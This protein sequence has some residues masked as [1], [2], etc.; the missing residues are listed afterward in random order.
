MQNQ[1]THTPHKDHAMMTTQSISRAAAGIRYLTSRRWIILSAGL[2]LLSLSAAF[3]FGLR[4]VS[5]ATLNVPGTYPTIQAAVNAAA[6]G[7]T[8]IVAAGTYTETVTIPAAK[9]GLI[10]RGA[11]AGVD[12]RNPRGA[13]SI[14]NG[15]GGGFNVQASNVVIDGFTVRDTSGGL[16][17]GIVV[18]GSVSGVKILNNI[19]RDN[20]IGLYLNGTN[21]EARQNYFLNNTLA[22]PAGGNAIYSDGGTNG[23]IVDKNRFEGHDSSAMVFA[24]P[25]GCPAPFINQNLT[26]TNN[27]IL[28]QAGI[29]LFDTDTAT[30]QGNT[31]QDTTTSGVYLGGNDKNIT[32]NFNNFS[33]APAT[34][35]HNG[36]TIDNA[37]GIYCGNGPGLNITN[38]NFENLDCAIVLYD[39]ALVDGTTVEAHNNRIVG[40]E[41]VGIHTDATN[42]TVDAGQNWWGCNDVPSVNGTGG[43]TCHCNGVGPAG[44]QSPDPIP[45]DIS[46]AGPVINQNNVLQLTLHATPDTLTPGGM[47]VVQIRIEGLN[48]PNNVPVLLLN[49]TGSSVG[50]SITP[51]IPA[52]SLSLTGGA[53]ALAKFTAG[54]PGTAEI[55]VGVDCQDPPVTFLINVPDINVGPGD[56]P[57]SDSEISDQKAGSMLVYNYYTSS[58]ANPAQENARINIT[59]T[60]PSRSVNVHLF[61]IDGATCS[62]A[63]SFACLTPNQTMTF[64]AADIDP[65][66]SGY[67]VALAID[68]SGCPI[69]FNYLIGD[70]YVKQA[71]GHAANLGAEAFSAISGVG[72]QVADGVHMV[73]C[74][75]SFQ[76][77]IKMDGRM[78]NRVPRVLALDN[79]LSPAEGNQTLVIIN[80]IGG[81]LLTSAGSLGDMFGLLFDDQER[82]ASFTFAGG[83]QVSRLL[84]N[85]FPRTTP[86]LNTMIPAGQS[87]WMKF[88][89]TSDGGILGAAINFNQN[90][91]GY[92]QGHNLH[93]L[94]L[95]DVEIYTL[96]VFPTNCN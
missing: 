64:M 41:T 24:G 60:N 57:S 93:K 5:A 53:I 46:G 32:V 23:V 13:E 95:S 16:G 40:S 21:N 86:R 77:T 84:S 44:E 49:V 96:P 71:T 79:I 36:V 85:N 39:D 25:T 47:A 78:Y 31:F 7:D 74:G 4:S 10:I 70:E 80:R 14:V 3:S 92:V 18:P 55:N 27:D 66:I 29:G 33:A 69:K 76:T 28:N 6:P 9:T 83:C 54:G 17:A 65:G 59:N 72:G 62:V 67:I 15:A 91:T 50:S 88:W 20:V 82:S 61:F 45:G 11:Q 35:A 8:I 63:D 68:H 52:G 30:I 73:D 81:N 75:S 42:G 48:L 38:N 37:N 89:K 12:A 1:T 19:I 2:A 22:G 87:G 51:Q 90:I 94:T 26:I 58:I 34:D 56:P 43:G